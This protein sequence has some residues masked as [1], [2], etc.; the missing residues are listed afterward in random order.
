[1]TRR[2]LI[3]LPLLLALT[4]CDRV[5]GLAPKA[6]ERRLIVIPS[7][8]PR[9]SFRVT[10]RDERYLADVARRLGTTVEAIIRDNQLPDSTIRTGQQ[11]KVQTTSRRFIEFERLQQVR[12]ERRLKR[13]E[14]RRVAEAAKAAKAAEL[15]KSRSKQ[16]RRA[17][18]RPRHR[19][20]AGKRRRPHR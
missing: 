16:R 5:A 6:P 8:P 4:G 3:L 7:A 1:M 9:Q 10:V 14:A 12:A 15:K 18:R 20:K 17:R 13:A 19:H 2:L 11:L